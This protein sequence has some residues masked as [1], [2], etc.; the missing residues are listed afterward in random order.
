MT[1]SVCSNAF[2]APIRRG[3]GRAAGAGLGL[4][5]VAAILEAHGGRVEA[6]N[7]DGGG[8]AFRLVLPAAAAADAARPAEA[9][10]A[11]AAQP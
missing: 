8:A 1:A 5:I 4:S 10:R 3:R 2:T 9:D 6:A 7:R 11:T